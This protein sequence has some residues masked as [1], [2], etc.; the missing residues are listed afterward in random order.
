MLKFLILRSIFAELCV[1]QK[2]AQQQIPTN[3]RIPPLETHT[4]ALTETMHNMTSIDD[5]LQPDDQIRI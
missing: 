4:P 5:L 1:Y 2:F 3:T